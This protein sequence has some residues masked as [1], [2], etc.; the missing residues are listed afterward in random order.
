MIDLPTGN[1]IAQSA[2]LMGDPTR[3]SML[4]A[5]LGGE[6]LTAGELASQAGITPQTASG[7]LAK[8]LD[9]RLIAAERQGRHRY[10]RLGSPAVAQAMEAMMALSPVAPASPAKRHGPRD[11]AM[12]QA[13]TCYDHMAGRLAVALTAAFERRGFLHR[14]EG[15]GVVSDEGHRFLCDFGIDLAGTDFAGIARSKRPLCRM[16]L[17]WSERRPHLAGRLGAALLTRTL[18]LGWVVRTPNSR[19]LTITQ[20]GDR[21]FSDLIAHPRTEQDRA[22]MSAGPAPGSAPRSA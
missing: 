9:G 12:R 14:S 7:H 21:G 6:A 19:T 18:A 15:V 1:M 2:H 8:L 10:F 22:A 20:A 5:L 11:E 17:D 3:A 13:R 4:A 16:C